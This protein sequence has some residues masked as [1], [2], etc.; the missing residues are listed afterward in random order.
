MKRCENE[1]KDI[2]SY[3]VKRWKQIK[4]NKNDIEKNEIMKE[5]YKKS[6]IEKRNEIV[7]KK[8]E[9]MRCVETIVQWRRMN[10]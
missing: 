2:I 3:V 1:C 9:I 6:E 10:R 5:L 7:E 4:I 8:S